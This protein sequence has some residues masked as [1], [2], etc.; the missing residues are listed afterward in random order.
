MILSNLLQFHCENIE[1]MSV[2]SLLFFCFLYPGVSFILCVLLVRWFVRCNH[3]IYFIW[4]YFF[5]IHLLTF[6]A[7]LFYQFVYYFFT[8]AQACASQGVCSLPPFSSSSFFRPIV[9]RLACN[10]LILY[11]HLR[12]LRH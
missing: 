8:P 3:F 12:P 5:A 1:S 10:L 2:S 6:F 11:I 4:S 7:L 9:R